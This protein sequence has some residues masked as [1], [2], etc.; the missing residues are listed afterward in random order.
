MEKNRVK[1][2]QVYLD[3]LMS[4][5][6]QEQELLQRIVNKLGDPTRSIAAK[7]MYQL[8]VL[9][10]EHPAMKGVVMDEVERLFYRPNV[11]PRAQYFGICFLSQILLDASE[12]VLADRAVKIYL[13]FFK[14]CV[15]KG[16]INTK[17]M[18]ALLTGVNR[19]FPYCDKSRRAS[20][21]EADL[22]VLF[23]IVQMSTFNV[24]VQAL[25][26]AHQV[27]ESGE[28][29]STDRFYSALYR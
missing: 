22:K 26:L 17:L 5:P 23:K 20:S 8:K 6:E 13:G 10:G 11:S 15:K 21:L 7:A 9:L 27:M 14:A 24:S 25:M 4:N 2:M 16:E 29:A 19:A 3:L 28:K 18:S 1:A 12:S